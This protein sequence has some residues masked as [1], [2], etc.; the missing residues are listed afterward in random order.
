MPKQGCLRKDITQR[1]ELVFRFLWLFEWPFLDPFLALFEQTSKGSCDLKVVVNES[2]IEV[3]KPQEDLEIV[4]GFGLQPLLNSGHT[5]AIH[6]S[7]HYQSQEF[8]F[9]SEEIAFLQTCVEAE[10]TETG[11]HLLNMI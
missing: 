7:R 3:C 6:I 10:T 4:V 11:K 8:N 9:D 2:P 5:P 1:P